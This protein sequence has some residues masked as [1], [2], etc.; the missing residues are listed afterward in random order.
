MSG[1]SSSRSR[2]P[3]GPRPFE[4]DLA[5]EFAALART[6]QA[7]PTLNRT[8][9][10]VCVLAVGITSA[11]EAAITVVRND[12]FTTVASTGDLPVTVDQIQYKTHEGP[13]VQSLVDAEVFVTADLAGDPRWPRFAARASAETGVRSMMS[14]RLSVKEGT[15]GALN[16][17]STEPGAFT[18]QDVAHMRL[19]AAHASVALHSSEA[20]EK[21][22]QLQHALTSNRRIGTA[23]GILMSTRGLT[24]EDAF[25][26]L[27]RASMDTNLKLTDV[28]EQVLYTGSLESD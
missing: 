22:D 18:E 3:H 14:H 24:E 27:R 26:A 15:I 8:L 1:S 9:E 2:S 20:E 25:H 19:F 13:C 28:A 16:T 10:T 17:Y 11:Q 6:L 21:V 5:A 7:Q 12:R 4:T 23:I